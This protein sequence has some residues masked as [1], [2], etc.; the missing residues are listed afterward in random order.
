MRWLLESALPCVG[1]FLTFSRGGLPFHSGAPPALAVP[2]TAITRN[3][4]RSR[5]LDT[6]GEAFLHNTDPEPTSGR[7]EI[8][9]P[10]FGRNRDTKCGIVQRRTRALVALGTDDI[11]F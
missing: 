5:R 2:G 9:H 3:R 10:S 6:S 1:L 7:I 8:P 4:P 11:I